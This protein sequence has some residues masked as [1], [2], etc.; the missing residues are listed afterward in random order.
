MKILSVPK[1]TAQIIALGLAAPALTAYAE[2]PAVLISAE[3]S[4]G[5]HLTDRGES[6]AAAHTQVGISAAAEIGS[7][8]TYLAIGKIVP[9]LSHSYHYEDEVAYSLGYALEKKRWSFD[10]SVNHLVYPEAEQIN[11]TELVINATLKEPLEPQ[12]TVFYANETRDYGLEGRIGHTVDMNDWA[13]SAAALAGF[14]TIN[15]GTDRSYVGLET[16]L[17]TAISRSISLQGYVFF[18]TADELSFV[19]SFSDNGKPNPSHRATGIG[20]RLS[21][22]HN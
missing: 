4:S 5:S 12:I 10:L 6:L 19:R 13:L 20:L 15:N 2:T 9:V 11:E 8:V 3:I 7:G 17:S 21:W 22:V 14:V 18:T 1:N 16:A